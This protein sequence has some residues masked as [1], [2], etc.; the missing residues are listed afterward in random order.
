MIRPLDIA[1]AGALEA[2]AE[3]ALPALR[4]SRPAD[5]VSAWMATP[6][7]GVEHALGA[8]RDGRLVAAARVAPYP[9]ARLGH[10]A[11]AHLLAAPGADAGPVLEAMTDLVDAWTA[12]D[13]LQLELPADHPA[14]AAATTVGFSPEVVR[15]GR[16]ADGADDLALGRLRPGF[17]PR[18]AGPPP[19]WPARGAREAG[20]VEIRPITDADTDAVCRLSTETTTVWGTLQTPSSSPTFYRLRFQSTPGDHEIVVLTV[21]GEVAGIGGLHPAGAPGVVVLGM[22]IDVGWQAR[23]LGRRLLDWLV[24]RAQQAGARRIELSLWEDNHR[25]RALY[26]SRG[27]IAEGV[28][29]FDAI[30]AGGHGSSLDMALSP[31]RPTGA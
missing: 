10:A 22:A 11:Q 4:Q 17:A 1:D 13:R 14:L 19:P 26:A 30:R 16:H 8:W 9:R 20:H 6:S 27:F 25:A 5:T 28:R 15:I 24:D 2:L 18:P 12:L 7:G 29:R 31:P 21:D 23:G 3:A